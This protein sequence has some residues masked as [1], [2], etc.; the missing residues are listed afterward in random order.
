MLISKT[1][2]QEKNKEKLEG[3]LHTH[4]LLHIF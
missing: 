2:L 4:T 3:G 1:F